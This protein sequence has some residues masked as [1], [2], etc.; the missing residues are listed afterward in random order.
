MVIT[1]FGLLGLFWT[2]SGAHS[3]VVASAPEVLSASAR[4]PVPPERA[5]T[6]ALALL[7]V[8]T[9]TFTTQEHVRR[10]ALLRLRAVL[11]SPA[12]LPAVVRELGAVAVEAVDLSAAGSA[13]ARARR[14]GDGF[15]AAVACVVSAQ[16]AENAGDLL[17]AQEHALAG[18]ELAVARQET[19]GAASAAM[20]LGQ[21]ASEQARPAEALGWLAHAREGMVLLEATADLDEAAWLEASSLVAL[22]RV[23]EA[24]VL[25]A[26]LS[27]STEDPARPSSHQ[28]AENAR[29]V[30]LSGRA[31]I[32]FVSGDPLAALRLYGR[33]RDHMRGTSSGRSPWFLVFGASIVCLAVLGDAQDHLR[34]SAPNLRARTVAQ[35]RLSPRFTDHPILG[36][37]SLALGAYLVHEVALGRV[38]D[39][40]LLLAAAERLGS[41]QDVPSLL[42]S[43]HEDA[44]RRLHGDAA[45]EAARSTVRAVPA[46][47]LVG[48]VL[49][50]LRRGP[51]E[52]RPR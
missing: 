20:L 50:V 44:A 43:T 35:Q 4:T 31:E 12:P 25:L 23:E 45:L 11:C 8:L 14:S 7:V 39:G 36:T 33:A 2:L 42:R 52:Q 32:A 5:G 49:D 16:L 34:R 24:E 15:V 13:L 1:V 17:Q 41:R 27:A 37:A 10:R 28:D 47:G 26:G 40:L 51:W 48:L 3:D 9:T 21:L 22:G 29:A 38:E 19:W 46:D 18:Y 6:V 30:H